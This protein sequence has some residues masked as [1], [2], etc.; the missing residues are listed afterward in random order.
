MLTFLQLVHIFIC[1]FLILLILIQA[2]KGHGLAGAFG[3]FAGGAAQNLFGA[4]T[5]DVLTKI[6]GYV[7]ALFFISALF[8]AFMQVKDSKSVLETVKKPEVVEEAKEGASEI[9]KKISEVTENLL[10]KSDKKEENVN[11]DNEE[12]KNSLVSNEEKEKT[13]D[14]NNEIT[15]HNIST[16]ETNNQSQELTN[17]IPVSNDITASE[18]SVISQTSDVVNTSTEENMILESETE[19]SKEPESELLPSIEETKEVIEPVMNDSVEDSSSVSEPIMQE[20]NI[21][22]EEPVMEENSDSMITTTLENQDL[23]KIEDEKKELAPT[24]E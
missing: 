18:E 19:S 11:L 9:S 3:S 2:G 15:F 16:N 8:L 4:R 6:T 21:V 17:E 14:L 7:A 22:V 1:I 23:N 10:K 5:T 12:E 20:N 13:K 24:V